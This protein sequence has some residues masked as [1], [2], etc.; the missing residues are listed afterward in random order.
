LK[1]RRTCPLASPPCRQRARFARSF[2]VS[3]SALPNIIVTA[4]VDLKNR[5]TSGPLAHGPHYRNRAKLDKT[6]RTEGPLGRKKA[7]SARI[8]SVSP[9]ATTTL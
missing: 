3:P 6:K 1:T 2:A 7:R 5:R 9:S 8:F 4:E